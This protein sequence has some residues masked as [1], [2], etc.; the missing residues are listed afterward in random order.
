MALLAALGRVVR[1]IGPIYL[2]RLACRLIAYGL[3]GDMGTTQ[4]H[5]IRPDLWSRGHD[6]P[7]APEASRRNG[8]DATSP[9]RMMLYTDHTLSVVIVAV[10]GRNLVWPGRSVDG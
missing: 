4:A 9:A 2:A 5:A 3:I 10:P 7:Q 1:T 6:A 8:W